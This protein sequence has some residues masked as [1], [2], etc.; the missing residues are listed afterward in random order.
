MRPV[1]Y[2]D[3]GSPYAYLAV[4]RAER[5][6]ARPV[7]LEPVLLGAIF[8]KRGRGS[9][10]QTADHAAQIAEV[11][12]RA[13]A[14]GLPAVAWP[15]GW[16]PD[17][18][19]MM[20]AATWSKREGRVD[21][22]AR[23]VYEREFAR[24]E[25]VSGVDALAAIADAVGLAGLREAIDRPDIEA[26]LREATDRAWDAGVRGVPS[27]VVGDHVLYGDDQLEKAAAVANA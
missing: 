5:V 26:A 22:F 2:F 23:A 16:P 8:R 6:F 9:W 3:L 14:Y 4:A 19:A 13:A 21:A 11:E 18:L 7:E 12:R 17:G 15:P 25:D 1:L 27:I 20:R 10:S 24:G